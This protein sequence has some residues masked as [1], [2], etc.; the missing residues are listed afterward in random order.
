MPQNIDMDNQDDP[1][2]SWMSFMSIDAQVGPWCTITFI[3]IIKMTLMQLGVLDVIWWTSCVLKHHWDLYGCLWCL[4]MSKMTHKAAGC[5]L[6][7]LM[8]TFCLNA[9]KH[10]YGWSRWPLMHLDVYCCTSCAAGCRGCLSM[11]QQ[12][13]MD[14][15]DDPGCSWM[16]LMS[17]NAPTHFCGC[18]RWPS[19]QLDAQVGPRCS[20][21]YLGASWCTWFQLDVPWCIL[22]YRV[23]Q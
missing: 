14:A 22:M 6:A 21:M 16:S 23:G 5:L 4:W 2:S 8:H 12:I 13:Y 20:L 1:W 9:P 11:H 17:I 18:K 10:L 3:G 19:M 15:Q 7:I